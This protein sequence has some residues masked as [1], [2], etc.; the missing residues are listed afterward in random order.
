MSHPELVHGLKASGDLKIVQKADMVRFSLDSVLL[1]DFVKIGARVRKIIDFGT[2]LGPIPLLLSEKTEAMIIGIELDHEMTELARKSVLLNHLENQI[3]IEEDDI[4]VVHSH[5]GP[6]AFELVTCN[7]PF[8]KTEGEGTRLTR[9]PT[10][11]NARHETTIDFPTLATQAK[12]L[13]K[14][15]GAFVFI[16]RSERLEEIVKVLNQT[17]FVI[18]RMRFVYP[19]PDKDALMVLIEARN[20]GASGGLKVLEPLYIQDSSGNYGTEA[21]KIFGV[22]GE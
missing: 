1:A 5:Y 7:P 8:F 2:G 21:R 16:Q 10:Q 14:T 12:R 15:G 19:K 17:G 9:N 22:T 13:L 11:R 6:A 4:R 18:K 3:R 20:G